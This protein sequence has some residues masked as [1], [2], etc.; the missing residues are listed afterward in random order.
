M[1][2]QLPRIALHLN[3]PDLTPLHR[4]G[5]T[6]LW[7]SLK[8]L[9]QQYPLSS[10]RVGNLSWILTPKE[11]QL[12]W[13]GNDFEV[14]DWL[15]KQAFQ[16]DEEG[17]I[18][19]LAL[20]FAT[21]EIAC[22]ILR[23]NLIRG[24]FL[25]HN[26]FCRSVGDKE[27]ELL[28]NHV[29]IKLSYKKVKWY[30]AQDFSGKL[31][32]DQGNLRTE[33]IKITGGLY[34]GATVR[35]Y[36]YPK[37]TAF[38][39]PPKLAFALLFAPI[40]SRFYR[41]SPYSFDQ[42]FQFVLIIPEVTNLEESAQES[43]QAIIRDY[44]RFYAC[45]ASEA[46]L[47]E[48]LFSTSLLCDEVR[49][50]RRFEGWVFGK[51]QWVNN[52]IAITQVQTVTVTAS[53][54]NDYQTVCQCF[55]KATLNSFGFVNF[56]LFREL[57]CENLSQGLPWWSD[58]LEK[59]QK[60]EP[61]NHQF[62]FRQLSYQSKA[63]INLMNQLKFNDENQRLFVQVC[64]EALSKIYGKIYSQTNEEDRPRF[65]RK[66]QELIRELERCQNS[67]TFRQFMVKFFNQAGHLTL[68]Q[69]HW[70]ELMPLATGQADWE[71]AK[72][73]VGYAIV[74]YPGK[75]PQAEKET[76]PLQNESNQMDN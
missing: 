34:P 36:K 38:E 67:K 60:L 69:Q 8:C 29:K 17:L 74:S 19:F 31:C 50:S 52:Q 3:A 61:Q 44:P 23:H 73:L 43:W 40:A 49:V 18:C 76:N 65:D 33:P 4:V 9:E 25:Q 11:I 56:S 1:S 28:V 68:L 21:T 64:H 7:M 51:L 63:L 27:E 35:H 14:L 26:K 30:F 70:E 37:D 24:T 10:Q 59:L 71:I 32:G 22:K 72:S 75:K 57:I 47:K 58:F 12:F 62:F 13:D 16:I 53:M 48:A 45:S 66:N 5:L 15:L 6:G 2:K 54:L 42:R 20:K 39:E 55:P 46:I 41:L